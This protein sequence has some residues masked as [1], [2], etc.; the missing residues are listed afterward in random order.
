MEKRFLLAKIETELDNDRWGSHDVVIPFT[1]VASEE[2]GDKIACELGFPD[3]RIYEL[4]DKGI[5]EF[6]S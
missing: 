5:F 1:L 4:N 6:V 2:E 3:W